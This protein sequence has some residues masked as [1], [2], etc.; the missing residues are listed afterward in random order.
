[1]AANKLFWKESKVQHCYSFLATK[2]PLLS[3]DNKVVESSS[4]RQS[5]IKDENKDDP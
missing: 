3:E 2:F 5:E 1:M 4:Y